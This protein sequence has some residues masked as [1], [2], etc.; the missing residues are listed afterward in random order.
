MEIEKFYA[1]L[2]CYKIS[3]VGDKPTIRY[4]KTSIL[5]TISQYQ[6]KKSAAFVRNFRLSRGKTYK[7]HVA[8]PFF[9]FDLIWFDLDF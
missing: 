2:V 8:R 5:K 9:F 4:T 6:S 7:Q 1:V 3:T